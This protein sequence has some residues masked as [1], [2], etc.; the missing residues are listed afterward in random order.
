MPVRKKPTA[1]RSVD[2]FIHAAGADKPEA[3]GDSI[4]PVKL[5]VPAGLLAQVDA[6]VNKRRPSP[7][8]HQWILE[9]L[10][11]KLERDG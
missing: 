1:P 2:E 11:E 3:N 4:L 8:R 10:Y 7:S 5:R 9:A 6:A